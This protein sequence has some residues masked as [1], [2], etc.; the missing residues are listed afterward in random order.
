MSQPY[1]VGPTDQDVLRTVMIVLGFGA[2]S[3]AWHSVSMSMSIARVGFGIGIGSACMNGNE[4]AGGILAL[5]VPPW[6]A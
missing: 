2:S 1:P 6:R 3:I 5:G 4:R